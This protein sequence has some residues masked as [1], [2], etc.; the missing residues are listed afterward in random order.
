MN[1]KDFIPALV[2]ICLFVLDIQTQEA[3]MYAR[4][5][6]NSPELKMLLRKL[7]KADENFRK[8][9]IYILEMSKITSW[10]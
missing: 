7:H 8:E 10:N 6:R 3:L 4:K 1:E 9:A 2:A 5:C